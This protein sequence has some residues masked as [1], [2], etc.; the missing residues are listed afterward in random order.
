MKVKVNGKRINIP[1]RIP[2]LLYI[3]KTEDSILV[4]THIGI[5]ILWDGIS[6]LEV[7]APTF[8]RGHLCGLCGNFNSLPKDDF[9]TPRGRILQ[10][11][12]PFGQSWA[13][14]GK[15][16]CSRKPPYNSDK[17]HRCRGRRDRR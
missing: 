14:G 17:E 7:S 1:Y 13:I 5:K 8:Y 2:K 12:H 15:K 3:N 10:E 16:M 11:S 4:N 6:F 9:A